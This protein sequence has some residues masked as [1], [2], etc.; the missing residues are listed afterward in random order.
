VPNV[1]A[2]YD[3]VQTRLAAA[4]APGVRRELGTFDAFSFPSYGALCPG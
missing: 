4:P 1:K 3:L 2:E